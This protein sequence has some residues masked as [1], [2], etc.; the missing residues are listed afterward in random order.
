MGAQL[1]EAPDGDE[2]TLVKLAREVDA[3]GTNWAHVTEKVIRAVP[4]C[5]IVARFGI[6]L[7][8]ICIKTATELG[9]PVT[10]VP[11][12]CVSEVSDHAL[13]LILACARNIAFFHVRTKA[14]EY[15]LSAG[16]PM[17]R[18]KGATLGLVG[19]GRIAQELFP[20]ARAI[21]FN[22][23]A[24]SQHADDRGTGCP[25]VPLDELLRQQR[26]HLAACAS[27]RFDARTFRRSAI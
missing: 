3:I 12:Y 23:I 10:N 16:P 8:N 6:G 7:D 26:F 25:M 13:A 21:G 19:F 27:H 2:S 20:K 11:D 17:R 15:N 4:R 18:L 24:H 9:I 14:G 1:V 5:R 22:V